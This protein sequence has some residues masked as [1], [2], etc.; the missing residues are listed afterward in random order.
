MI[1]TR[2]L[3]PALA[4]NPPWSDGTGRSETS[5]TAAAGSAHDGEEPM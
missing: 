5:E 2:Q 4:M 3:E 1:D